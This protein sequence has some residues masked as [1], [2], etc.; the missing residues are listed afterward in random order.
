MNSFKIKGKIIILVLLSSLYLFGFQDNTHA[1]IVNPKQTYTYAMMERDILAI[2]AKY[3]DLVSYKVIGKSEYGRDIFAVSVGKGPSNIL[4]TGSHHARE[5]MTT[6]LSMHMIDQYAK[7]YQTNSNFGPYRTRNILNDSTIWFVPMLNPD[8]VELQ[9]RGLSA[10][11]SSQHTS[12]LVMNDGSPNFKR[13]KA[14]GKGVDLNR[15]YDA[16]WANIRGNPG[17]PYYQNYKGPAPHSSREVQALVNFTHQID[18][19]MAINY[20]SSGEVLFWNYKQ[21]GAR[22]QRDLSYARGVSNLTGYTLIYSGANPSGGG[23]T[24]WFVDKWHRPALTPELGRYVGQTNLPIS[25]YDRIWQQNQRVGL[26]IAQ[27]GHKLFVPRITEFATAQVKSSQ[28]LANRLDPYY[29]I[30]D[31]GDFIIS[32][33]FMD[34]YN[35]NRRQISRTHT[36]LEKINGGQKNW[37]LDQLA[38][39]EEKVLRSAYVIDVGNNGVRVNHASADVEAHIRADKLTDSA[40]S[41]YHHLSS[42]IRRAENSIG[43]LPGSSNRALASN[44]FVLPAKI[45]REALIFEVTLYELYNRAEEYLANGQFDQVE[46]EL[47]LSNRI[48]NRANRIKEDGNRLHPGMYP[49]LNGIEQQLSS[50]EEDIRNRLITMQ[51]SSQEHMD[52]SAIQEG[53]EEEAIVESEGTLDQAD[54]KVTEENSQEVAEETVEG[55]KFTEEDE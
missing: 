43:R 13:W 39:A 53:S 18:P 8:G 11:P 26:Y 34:L 7:A 37:L 48:Q 19:E 49:Q 46:R 35:H 20:H 51:S 33:E 47:S 45:K 40:V 6:N 52:S 15:Q 38:Y 10:L 29:R 25:A 4:I 3:P 44:T 41:A 36:T 12:L 32:K 9:Q 1:S 23:M 21:S 28:L 55:T 50:W 31:A 2:A 27:E 5:W 22:Y 30:S 17:R 54:D 24:D 16:N 14:N 42:E